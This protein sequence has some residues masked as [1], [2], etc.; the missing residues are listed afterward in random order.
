[1]AVRQDS[2]QLRVEFIT[3]ESRQLASTLLTTK[4]Y[5]D[6][7]NKSSVAIKK[8]QAELAKVGADEAK[9]AAI[10]N[11]IALEEQ[12]VATNLAAVAAEGKKVQALDLSKIAPAQLLDRAKQLQQA[13]RLI[14]QSAPEFRVLQAELAKVNGQLRNINETSKGLS[15]GAAGGGGLF[16]RILGVAGGI[17][18]FQLVQQAIGSLVN[19]GRTA[20]RELDAGLKADAQVRA[21]IESTKSAAGRSFEELNTQAQELAKVTLFDDDATKGAQALLLTFKNVKTEVFDQAIP[22]AQD[23]STAFGQDLKS[24]AIQLG[25]ALDDPIRGVTALRRVGVSFSEDQQTLIKSLVETGRTA[26]A[27]RIILK[28]LET[29]V[30]GSAKAAAEAGLGPYQVLQNRLGEVRESI[31]ALIANGLQKLAPFLLRVVSFVEQLTERLTTGKSAVGEYSTAVNAVATIFNVVAKAFDLVGR[32]LDFQIKTWTTVGQRIGD[33]IDRVRELPV[34]GE[35][36]E[37]FIITPIR[38]IGDAIDNLPAA[39]AGF[40]AATKQ[41]GINIAADLRGL[42]LDAKIFV[43]N[44]EAALTFSAE[45]KAKVAGELKG[46][47]SQKAVAAQAGKTI[48]EAYVQARDAVL[49][50][51]PGAAESGGTTVAGEPPK[52]ELTADQIAAIKKRIDQRVELELKGIEL[53]IQK[54]ELLLENE[55][56]KGLVSEKEYQDKLVKITEDGLKQKL[57][58]YNVF[59]RDQTVEALKLANELAIIEQ[60]RAVGKV[61]INTIAAKPGGAV[62]S[63]STGGGTEQ[64]LGVQDLGE[65][66]REAALAQ[67]FQRMLIT[68][69]DYELQRLELKKQAIAEEIAI[70]QEGGP[71][72]SAA[73]RKKEEEAFKIEEEIAAKK[74]ENA[75]RTE[76]LKIKVQQAGFQAAA[77]FFSLAAELLAQD[78]KARKKNAGAIKAFQIAEIFTTGIL[79]AQRSYAESVKTFGI[80]AGPVLGAIFAG[81]A[82][83]R[84]LVAANK[85]ASTKFF[86]GGYTGQGYGAPDESGSRPAGVV[87]AGEYVAPAW[88]V[89]N[90]ETGPVVAWLNNRR[91]RGYATGGFVAPNTTPNS[92]IPVSASSSTQIQGIDQFT[93]AVAMFNETARNFPREVKSRVVYTEIEDAGTELKSVRDDAAL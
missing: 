39:W 16:Q 62:T 23:L 63:Q 67:R 90:P 24:S 51:S 83:G 42:V 79:E 68:E 81:L 36:F 89:N 70:L 66:A 61:A 60:G 38:F 74:V 58:V 3:D 82:I 37:T 64:A 77:G 57:A 73:V 32:L 8:Y 29:Q 85:V 19:F 48:G 41:A 40:V 47:E 88:Q 10:L 76:D 30:G 44:M 87:H 75:Q 33:F 21:A 13:M 72:Y 12:K 71:E 53:G 80:P 20:L 26:E 86:F 69:Q 18:V 1:M 2:V 15:G 93:Q 25:K 35:L 59:K 14:P 17:G 78:E 27:Q 54:Q 91:L 11:K 56:I 5:T 45:G 84:S 43:K 92:S 28:E 46:L 50:K 6:E 4:Q 49:A 31:G 22:L 65:N 34:V 52:S 7:I 55:R 9:R